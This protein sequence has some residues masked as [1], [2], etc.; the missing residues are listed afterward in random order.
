MP[1][2][3]SLGLTQE[4]RDGAIDE[5]SKLLSSLS[6]M[7]ALL[8]EGRFNQ[9]E[10][11]CHMSLLRHGYDGL[12]GL[13]R[14]DLLSKELDEAYAMLRRANG[15]VTDLKLQLGQGVTA[16]AAA[17]KLE[18][19]EQWFCTW[20]QLSGFHYMTITQ[21]RY[22]LSFD[23]SD[24]IEH[25]PIAP[26]D[27]NFGDKALAV[28][29]AHVIPY[30]FG[31]ADLKRDTFH[32]NLLDTQANHDLLI[33]IFAQAFP[34]VRIQ[35][36]KSHVDHPG[37]FM[38]RAS[39]FVGWE[40]IQKWHDRIVKTAEETAGRNTGLYYVRVAE[41]AGRLASRVY[42]SHADKSMIQKDRE[43][44]ARVRS[45][46]GLWDQVTGARLSDNAEKSSKDIV[47]KVSE[48]ETHTFPAGTEYADV[49]EWFG[50][51][52]DLDPVRDLIGEKESRSGK[53]EPHAG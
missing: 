43:E 18:Q 47:L 46:V 8:S 39:G 1:D 36:F 6:F 53:E 42:T 3:K 4:A 2:N 32:D 16:S 45:I 19:L 14:M 44:L 40:D 50:N 26:E 28:K 33:K 51:R 20:Y 38:L 9:D 35:G 49:Q 27:V 34:D 11:K 37:E 15:E 21:N 29:I 22:G 41:I 10:A 30:A 52:F 13:F 5:I 7:K 24:E 31:S 12:A 48:E 17:S 23:S 25:P